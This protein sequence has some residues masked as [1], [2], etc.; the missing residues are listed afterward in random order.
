[1]ALRPVQVKENSLQ[2]VG[3]FGSDAGAAVSDGAA[4]VDGFSTGSAFGDLGR[5]NSG[6]GT[7]RT[8]EQVRGM[9]AEAIRRGGI[10]KSHKLPEPVQKHLDRVVAESGLDDEGKAGLRNAV[11]EKLLQIYGTA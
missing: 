9:L 7:P 8:R 10:E 11:A 2:A 4:K 6:G 5:V 1:M 3:G